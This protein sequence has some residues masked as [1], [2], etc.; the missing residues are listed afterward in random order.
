M[1]NDY[2]KVQDTLMYLSKEWKVC[3]NVVLAS[4]DKKGNRKF[5]YS[6]YQY[7]SKYI[8]SGKV[9]SVKRNFRASISIEQIG[10]FKNSVLINRGDMPILRNVVTQA[11][12]WLADSNVFGVK[13]KQLRILQEVHSQCNIGQNSAVRFEP[14]LMVDEFNQLQPAIRMYIND[15]RNYLDIEAKD[16][17]SFYELLRTFDFYGSAC[18]VIAGLPINHEDAAVNRMDVEFDVET[19]VKERWTKK[20]GFFDKE[21]EEQ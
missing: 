4:K 11:V 7:Q 12:S 6:E 19:A 10:N 5:F 20:K 3:F 1:L 15:E 18:A 8:D 9:V 14:L 13:E 2:E 16:F 21:K 17:Y